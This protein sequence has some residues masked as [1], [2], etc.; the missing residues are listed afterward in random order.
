MSL[1]GSSGLFVQHTHYTHVQQFH[2]RIQKGYTYLQIR[3]IVLISL[4]VCTFLVTFLT[5]LFQS[6][7]SWFSLKRNFCLH[8]DRRLGKIAH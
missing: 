2:N 8:I 7:T 4:E 5:H 6:F 3:V 1:L